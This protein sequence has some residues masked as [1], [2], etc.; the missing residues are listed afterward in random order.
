MTVK[1]YEAVNAINAAK[2]QGQ[3]VIHSSQGVDGLGLDVQNWQK[4][5]PALESLL[6]QSWFPDRDWV[7]E[8]I[9][10]NRDNAILRLSPDRL[11]QLQDVI[12]QLQPS[13]PIVLEAWSSLV[14]SESTRSFHVDVVPQGLPDLSGIAEKLD[15]AFKLLAVDKSFSVTV[16]E[17]FILVVPEGPYSH[18]CATFALYLAKKSLERIQS[19][20]GREFREMIKYLPEYT[21]N[22]E[23]DAEIDEAISRWVT[24]GLEEDWE[25]FEKVRSSSFPNQPQARANIE[26]AIPILHDLLKEGQCNI[27]SPDEF[28]YDDGTDSDGGEDRPM[29]HR[30]YGQLKGVIAGVSRNLPSAES[31]SRIALNASKLA[32]KM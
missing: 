25:W 13:L 11:N 6:N 23:K 26:K 32:E 9:N 27:E 8:L 20:S 3:L 30:A 2:E 29:L 1:I 4:L 12:N 31:I 21:E 7:R 10:Q 14:H 5:Y 22:P 16:S 15:G 18:F 19:A 17:G 24:D 28:F